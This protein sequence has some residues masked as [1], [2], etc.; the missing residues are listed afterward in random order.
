MKGSPSNAGVEW[1]WTDFH[2]TDISCCKWSGN[3]GSWPE[4]QFDHSAKQLHLQEQDH[5]AFLAVRVKGGGKGPTSTQLAEQ[6]KK[7]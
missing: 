4:Q 1:S 7:E 5:T 3:I 6:S 2:G